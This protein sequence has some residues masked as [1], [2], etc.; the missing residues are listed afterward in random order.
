MGDQGVVTNSAPREE[1]YSFS[2]TD[3]NGDD[4]LL[5]VR[6]QSTDATF[7]TRTCNDVAASTT[8]SDWSFQVNGD[9]VL[10]GSFTYTWPQGQA[11]GTFTQTLSFS[12]DDG[13]VTGTTTDQ[14]QFQDE[15]LVSADTGVY[16]ENGVLVA[17]NWGLWETTPGATNVDS[18]NHK[19]ADN[20]GTGAG[21]VTIQFTQDSFTCACGGSIDI[22]D[23]IRLLY[24]TGTTPASTTFTVGATDADGSISLTVPAESTLWIK[25]RINDVPIPAQS[26]QYTSSYTFTETTP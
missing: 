5:S 8:C 14:T 24:G 9:E 2:I 22:D 1:V 26:G 21:Q 20:P 17:E 23:N 25:Y 3:D 13:Y 16:D 19:R 10:T 12:D 4:T 6:V 11:E 7:G 18:A 15:A